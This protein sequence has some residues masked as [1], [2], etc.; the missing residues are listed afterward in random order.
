MENYTEPTRNPPPEPPSRYPLRE[1]DVA[2]NDVIGWTDAQVLTRL[3]EPDEK[4]EGRTWSSSD[5][6]TFWRDPAGKVIEIAVF[7]IVPKRIRIGDAYETWTYH[8]VRGATWLLFIANE[9]GEA[10]VVEVGQYLT[11]PVV[12]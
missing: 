1:Y 12:F 11:G 7:G 10:R 2:L 9:R 6:K 5:R 4:S 8:N 3:G